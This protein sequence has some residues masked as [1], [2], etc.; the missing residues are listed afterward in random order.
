MLI[1]LDPLP[2]DLLEYLR[3]LPSDDE[4]E[5]PLKKT[6]LEGN[7][8]GAEDSVCI[9]RDQL[10]ISRAQASTHTAAD[11][12]VSRRDIGRHLRLSAG[13]DPRTG[14]EYAN[15]RSFSESI[16]G[17]TNATLLLPRGSLSAEAIAI[18]HAAGDNGSQTKVGQ[19][20]GLSTVINLETKRRGEFLDLHFSFE[21]CWTTRLYYRHNLSPASIQILR[22]VIKVFLPPENQPSTD[23]EEWSPLDFYE[24]AHVPPK[25]D[26][27]ADSIDIPDMTA[28]LFP[29]QKRTLKWLLSREGVTRQSRQNGTADHDQAASQR[30]T[31]GLP[32]SFREIRDLNG[33]KCYLSEVLLLV[34]TDLTHFHIADGALSGGILAE[35]M[36]LVKTL[37]MIGL[38]LLHRR[39]DEEV[40]VNSQGTINTGATLIVT[41]E[42]LRR[43]WM[44]EFAR[45]APQLRVTHYSGCKVDSHE[46][47][48]ALTQELASQDVVVTT[49][50][51]LSTELNY[52][53]EPPPRPRRHERRYHRTKSPLMKIDWWRLCLD[54]AQMIESGV[55]RAAEVAKLV[56]RIHAWGITG[57]PVKNAVQDLRGLLIFLRYQPYNFASHSWKDLTTKYKPVFRQLFNRIA[58]R[59]TKA[60]VRSEI[61]L[62]RQ[63]RFVITLPFAAVEEQHYQSMFKEMA[64]D[65]GLDVQGASVD[66]NWDFESNSE[67]MSMW[68]NRLRQAALHPE[69]VM[70]RLVPHTKNRP[71]RT[72]DEVLDA[73]IEQNERTILIE[74]RAYF[75]A[76]LTRGQ[77]LENG[78]RVKEALALWQQVR[79]EITPVVEVYEKKLEKLVSETSNGTAMNG[80]ADDSEAEDGP[81]GHEHQTQLTD[82]RGRLR[83]ALEIQHRAVFFCGNAYFQIRENPELTEVESDEA[84]RLQELEDKCYDDAKRIRRK[85]LA[86]AS[87][88]LA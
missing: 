77:L 81:I 36:G 22:E 46:E 54:E 85:I 88:L 4:N 69:V 74:K 82:L 42:S 12:E 59:H 26:P 53:L 10:T 84:K 7:G 38:I 83:S 56:P 31:K 37:E 9:G 32:L 19:Q 16:P 17:S 23:A 73:M 41:P 11:E 68:L 76:R 62:P 72:V 43:Q 8:T 67:K 58:L 55:S 33:K 57:T 79:D 78:P 29:F 6:K 27:E 70:R 3:R 21:L 39:P 47:E 71:M 25:D 66:P 60:L 61:N 75:M 65:C 86:E 15:F 44:E 40:Q 45:H 13:T 35:E 28:S 18:L 80:D 5:P 64:D 52:V 1:V 48:I 87:E 49:Y 14:K 50:S 2:A 34:A 20:T 24:S 30:E 63:D 51:V